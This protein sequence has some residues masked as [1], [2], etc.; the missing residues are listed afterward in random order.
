MRFKDAQEMRL[1]Y[2][3]FTYSPVVKT[4]AMAGRYAHLSATHTQNV[5]DRTSIAARA[6]ATSLVQT[7]TKTATR[8]KNDHSN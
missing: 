7:A 5:V 3:S 6:A 2:L 1:E 8:D 4:L